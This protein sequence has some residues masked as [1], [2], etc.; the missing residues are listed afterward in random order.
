MRNRCAS[1]QSFSRIFLKVSL[2]L[3]VHIIIFQ[4]IRLLQRVQ[5]HILVFHNTCRLFVGEVLH[6]ARTWRNL[7]ITF[8]ISVLPSLRLHSF[9]IPTMTKLRL[10][11]ALLVES[12][13]H[14]VWRQLQHVL[15]NQPRREAAH[16]S[17][18]NDQRHRRVEIIR[19]PWI[20]F[21]IGFRLRHVAPGAGLLSSLR[22]L[23]RD[24]GGGG[25]EGGAVVPNRR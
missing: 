13:I 4:M 24:H 8:S 6:R 20:W 3:R 23:G 14:F 7:V 17:N 19:P 10:L 11:R 9:D 15:V 22:L 12:F 25:H 5:L 1:Y 18:R 16:S 21:F 2:S